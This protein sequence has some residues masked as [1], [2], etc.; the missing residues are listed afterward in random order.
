VTDRY[1]TSLVHSLA[2]RSTNAFLG[3]VDPSSTPLRDHL[4]RTLS[5]APGQA[6]ALLADPVFEAM[7]GWRTSPETMRQLAAEGLLSERL[8][9]A[10]ATKAKWDR[11]GEYLFPSSRQPFEHQTAAWRKL[12]EERPRSILVTSGTGSGKT[13]CFLV[14]ILDHLARIQQEER[15]IKGVRAL[16]LYPLNA[17]INSQR[18]R[19]RAWCGPFGGWVRFALYNGN[20]PDKAD[21][22]LRR[23]T[24]KEEVVDRHSL[25]ET[26]PPI[27]VTNS[28]MLE[29]M[30]VRREDKPILEQSQGK[31]RYV[32]L[33]EAHTYLGSHAA[34]TALMLRRVMHAFGVAAS[35]VRFIATSATIGDDS[36]R[37]TEQLRGFL[38]DL[39]GVNPSDVTI[40]RGRRQ[41]PVL[42][43][44]YS[45]V[46]EPLP[47]LADLWKA[48]AST[49]Y[50]S[51]ARNAGLRRLRQVL[52]ERPAVTLESLNAARLG[53][54]EGTATAV[55]VR[56][57]AAKAETLELIDL[58]TSGQS[59]E[60]A[61]LLRVRAHLF[62]RVQSGVWACINPACSGRHGTDLASDSWSLGKVFFE[63]RLSC[64]EC[65]GLVLEMV[66][67]HECGA[68]FLKA[69]L[70]SEGGVHRFVPTEPRNSDIDEDFALSDAGQDEEDEPV[71]EEESVH[72]SSV[73]LLTARKGTNEDLRPTSVDVRSGACGSDAADAV[74]L[75]ELEE[76]SGA[77]ARC[78]CCGAKEQAVDSLFRPIRAGAPLFL[79]NILPTLLERTPAIITRVR[80]AGGEP[81]IPPEQLP[82]QGRRLITFTDSRQGTARYAIDGQLD[83]ERNFVRSFVLHQLRAT[84]QDQ[85]PSASHITQLRAELA[86]AVSLLAQKPTSQFLLREI[87]RLE[88]QLSTADSPPRGALSWS[89]MQR[90][91]ASTRE[92]EH[93]MQH[94]WKHL[95]IPKL[96][97]SE[98]ANFLLLREFARRSKRAFSLET[99]GL[100]GLEYPRL[101]EFARTPD[102]WRSRGLGDHEWLNLLTVAV[103]FSVR[104]NSAVLVPDDYLSWLGAPIRPK[105]LVG[106]RS[107]VFGKDVTRWPSVHR[108]FGRQRLVRLL[109]KALGGTVADKETAS[110]VEACLED[111]WAQCSQIL[112]TDSRGRRLDF[113]R[114]VQLC[115]VDQAW[116]CPITRR[117]LRTTVAGWSPYMP[118]GSG[119]SLAKCERVSMPAIP[120][121][122]WVEASGATEAPE[123]RERWI[124]GDDQI[125][126]LEAR[127]VWNELSRR[128]FALSP[129]YAVSEHSAQLASHRLQ[130]LETRF[131]AGQL[132]VLSS[133]T[134]MEMGV[135]IGGLSAVAM[136]NAPPSP[137]SYRQRSGRAGRR[138]ERRAFSFTLCKATPHGDAVFRKPT[139]PFDTETYISDVSLD[140]ERIV[141]RHVNALALTRFFSTQLGH[142]ELRNLTCEAFYLATE[143]REATAQRFMHW[144]S[145]DALDDA[146]LTAGLKALVDRTVFE[147]VSMDSLLEATRSE[148]DRVMSAWQRELAPLEAQ[149][150]AIVDV[151][152]EDVARKA[153]ELQLIR[154]RKE[155]LLRELALRNFLPGHGFPTQVVS[156]RTT[157]KGDFR[158][159]QE[160]KEN[161]EN[162]FQKQG[163]PS[164]DLAIALREYA[165]G[166]SVAIDGRVV[167]VAGVA[168]NWKVP[169]EAGEVR[170][171]QSLRHA[172]RCP[173]CGS[174]Q[175]SSSLPTVCANPACGE[176]ADPARAKVYL[177]P[178]GF[179]VDFFRPPTN[180][181]SEQAYVP[182]EQPWVSASAA[183]W[184]PLVRHELGR[185][186]VS[187]RGRVFASSKGTSGQGF[188][189]CLVCGR[190]DS[191]HEEADLPEALLDHY[192]IVGKS[193][194]RDDGKCR[195]NDS[196]WSIKR[197][198]WLGVSRE[199]DVLE[200]QLLQGLPTE[201]EKRE[202]SAASIAVALRQALAEK[203]GVEEREIGW[204]VVEEFGP[205]AGERVWS[206]KLYD[207][208]TGGAGFVTQAAPYLP[209]LLDRAREILSCAAS[210]DT[211]CQ[212][213]IL[214]YDT[215]YN[216]SQLNRNDALSV[217]NDQFLA[218][219]VLPR[220]L[221]V[222][223]PE[224]RLEFETVKMAMAREMRGAD[225]VRVFIS[226][227][228]DGWD[229]EEWDLRRSISRWAG[230]NTRAQLLV[231]E[232]CLRSMDAG[233]I[234]RVAS[235]AESGQAEVVVIPDEACRAGTAY[236]LCEIRRSG[237]VISLATT[238]DQATGVNSHW[239]IGTDSIQVLV[240]EG[241]DSGSV[242]PQGWRVLDPASLRQAPAGTVIA[243]TLTSEL[244]GDTRYAATRLIDLASVRGEP[245]L[246]ERIA[247]NSVVKM[248]TY[249]DR[250]VTTPLAMRLVAELFGALRER[251]GDAAKDAIYSVQTRAL[252]DPRKPET[253]RMIGDNWLYSTDRAEIAEALM[254][255]FGVRVA[256][257]EVSHFGAEHARELRI[258]WADG[259]YWWLRLD[260]G[261]GFLEAEQR[262][263]FNFQA[264][265]QQ[266][267]TELLQRLRVRHR[268]GT[269]IYLSGIQK[270][271]QT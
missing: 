203:I 263:R 260:E 202:R 190:A 12:T 250:Y 135:D 140:S 178:A 194:A 210:C 147:G 141:Q 249:R 160:L 73:L 153:I 238:S 258:E 4:R 68:E 103:D 48:D 55:A 79:R 96:N 76:A 158:L 165:P 187:P 223:G 11:A 144:L 154:L 69:G 227:T 185:Y 105:P 59:D 129:Y 170:D 131:K 27:L 132:N 113:A 7:F 188:A 262:V 138:D 222:F 241:T 212:S 211:A 180:D 44:A 64:S 40:I 70:E 152:T 200:I 233:V 181:L 177:E 3:S 114:E 159:K 122:F 183:V 228:S 110:D 157:S 255:H 74:T 36:D 166:S 182:M 65:G 235:V 26:P 42:S 116:R 77:G 87:A 214:S 179:S 28:T 145:T 82:F 62:H 37:V 34:E 123:G 127:G 54:K 109:A 24:G 175:D 259:A 216:S 57:S 8:I 245:G 104:G 111:A 246:S 161:G 232:S 136:N 265:P 13:E 75:Y 112:A 169:L 130:S 29:Y 21:P 137:A 23:S 164:R 269:H 253:P 184:Q 99:L 95:P 217:L 219:L 220:E 119:D 171:V 207:T 88:Q 155:Y 5:A 101:R 134:T 189:V 9:Q 261:F 102:C 90:K 100:V 186:R 107:D 196:G 124:S 156:L 56:D 16:F 242:L 218:G 39:S 236:L 85:Q 89:E 150:Q 91:L 14:P 248:I 139:W 38:A 46:D 98:I 149:L 239:G 10:M 53:T 237:R 215:S 197:R 41:A 244:A 198:V 225:R 266:K 231:S 72:A 267:V 51:L 19:L 67:C 66:C 224:T 61:S 163:F 20:T 168:L 209:F 80:D 58:C 251:L 86:E 106:P 118:E 15:D 143:E 60:G 148:T 81:G 31:L 195:G 6:G 230:Q 226:G 78:I 192:P 167:Q 92:V 229:F 117:L 247:S 94:Q 205:V 252:K 83:A 270:S 25:R 49:R 52:L 256:F 71:V 199:T 115:E 43:D 176:A 257:S 191:D 45:G 84:A 1:F 133:S 264:P 206:I 201:P 22:T 97:P 35:D 271:E 120:N 173:A 254:T 32:V 125:R 151:S 30:M 108:G 142:G 234:N 208:A 128:V 18:D 172:Y 121:A 47:S 126:A 162:R 174:F 146:W 2:S 17:L 93:L 50:E 204:W 213:C 268:N 63:R 33:D 193:A 240:G 243:K 221:W